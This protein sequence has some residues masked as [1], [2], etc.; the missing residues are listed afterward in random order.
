MPHAAPSFEMSL[1][2][3]QDVLSAPSILGGGRLL[4]TDAPGGTVGITVPPPPGTPPAPSVAR[5]KG[6][7]A[8]LAPRRG[9]RSTILTDPRTFE[10]PGLVARRRLFAADAVRGTVLGGI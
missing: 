1:R 9:R 3:V 5:L 7:R 4:R 10:T 8:K 2:R 6:A